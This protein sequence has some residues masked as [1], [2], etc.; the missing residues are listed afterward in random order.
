MAKRG[1][2]RRMVAALLAAI[3]DDDFTAAK[4]LLKADA[5]L[6]A[7]VVNED[8]LYASAAV[9]H[10]LSL[11]DTALHLAAAG[12]RTEIVGGA[13][14]DSCLAR[15]YANHLKIVSLAMRTLVARRDLDIASI[16]R[17]PF[18][19]CGHPMGI[20]FPRVRCATLGCDRR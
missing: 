3:V 7:L 9:F 17:Q 11:G 1:A 13:A 15:V 2:N 19:G 14:R 12:Y 20:L 16:L 8:R 10:W 6:A 5:S 4:K 18:Q